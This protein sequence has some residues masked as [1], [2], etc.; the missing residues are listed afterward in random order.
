[1]ESKSTDSPAALMHAHATACSSCVRAFV[2]GRLELPVN[3]LGDDYFGIDDFT[4]AHRVAIKPAFAFSFDVCP[5]DILAFAREHKAVCDGC[6]S[7]EI[8]NHKDRLLY[9]AKN[10][11]T[12]ATVGEGRNRVGMS[13]CMT[14]LP[15]WFDYFVI[16]VSLIELHPIVGTFAS[17]SGVHDQVDV[18]RTAVGRRASWDAKENGYGW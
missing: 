9:V 13:R 14:G 8:V 2:A 1:M 10:A 5:E 4:N 18:L 7:P 11:V 6:S 17:A 3:G 15:W 16:F 12:L